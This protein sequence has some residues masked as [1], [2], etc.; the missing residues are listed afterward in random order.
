MKGI[1]WFNR[2]FIVIKMI[3][4]EEKYM[5]IYFQRY[6]NVNSSW[7]CSGNYTRR[8]ISTT[9]GMNYE[10]VLYI[11]SLVETGEVMI[12]DDHR[13]DDYYVGKTLKVF[14]EKRWE[15]AKVIQKQFRICRYEPSYQMCKTIQMKNMDD[16]YSKY[17]RV[18]E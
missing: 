15:A 2:P 7:H 3:L 1:D 11:K 8:L 18:L 14:D 10:Q 17:N 13:T 6:D 9:G 12:T 16:V 4:D 5:E